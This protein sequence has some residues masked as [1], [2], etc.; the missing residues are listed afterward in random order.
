MESV[1]FKQHSST[2]LGYVFISSLNNFKFDCIE[3]WYSCLHATGT[4]FFVSSFSFNMNFQE[5]LEKG[6][7]NSKADVYRFNLKNYFTIFN[8]FFLVLPLCAMK[9]FQIKS[10]LLVLKQCSVKSLF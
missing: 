2:L 3:G 10:L 9:S 8:F 6:K 5:L 7:Y 1:R 4:F